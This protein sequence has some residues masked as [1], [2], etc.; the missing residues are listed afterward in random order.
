M[1]TILQLLTLLA[2]FAILPG[3]QR[4]D[5]DE[6]MRRYENHESRIS[7][8]EQLV[9]TA[10]D[11]VSAMQGVIN[12]LERKIYVNSYKEIAGGYELSMSDGSKI[13]LRNGE[14]PV[15]GI[16]QNTDG[17]YYWTLNGNFMQDAAGKLIKAQGVDG[18][19][20]KTPMMRVNA[21]NYWEVSTDGGTSWQ[22][23]RDIAGNMILATGPQGP[24]GPVNLNISETASAV[25]ISYN[26]NTYSIPKTSSTTQ[27]QY[28]IAIL[29]SKNVGESVWLS[30][31]A[32]IIDRSEV[33]IDLNNNNV[34][35][36]NENIRLFNSNYAVSGGADYALGSQTITIHGKV[37][38]LQISGNTAATAVD[39]SQNPGLQKFVCRNGLLTSIKISDKGNLEY[40][41]FYNNK[42]DA[43]AMSNILNSLPDRTGKTKGELL[44]V[45]NDG[46]QGNAAPTQA[47]IDAAK[48]KNWD[49]F[50]DG[51][52]Q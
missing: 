24:A 17:F 19:N 49:V 35:D 51:V 32:E 29:S 45:Y 15:V 13:V 27:S 10:N 33:W 5:F 47:D 26:G 42:L 41:A 44:P 12:A 28:K 50:I 8:L 36:V 11:N 20:G 9:K 39:V 48:A 46:P 38:E 25:T 21:Q 43:N 14:T 37:T 2:F 18:T 23:V 31:N 40:F 7:N 34:R 1:K 22:A 6:I 4:T 16:K 52:Q 30:V 3:C